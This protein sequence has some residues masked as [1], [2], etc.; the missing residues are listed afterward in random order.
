ML[1][2]LLREARKARGVLGKENGLAGFG[3]LFRVPRLG[4]SVNFFEAG[5]L[6]VLAT[7]D[8]RPRGIKLAARV[9]SRILPLA[10]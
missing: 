6:L 10:R 1:S 5:S 3:P 2:G 7:Q 4:A 8:S 9:R